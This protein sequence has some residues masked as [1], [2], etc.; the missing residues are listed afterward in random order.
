MANENE[1]RARKLA[2]EIEVFTS[3]LIQTNNFLRQELSEM[4]EEI[5]KLHVMNTKQSQSLTEQ[6]KEI[7]SLKEQLEQQKK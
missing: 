3:N 4:K 1:Q 6:R 5:T 2:R 7:A